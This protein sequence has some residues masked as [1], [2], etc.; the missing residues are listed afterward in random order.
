MA[1]K[2]TIG[3][4][5]VLAA[6]NSLA[7][8]DEKRRIINAGDSSFSNNGAVT[9]IEVNDKE[10]TLVILNNGKKLLSPLRDQ[11]IFS[12]AWEE[13]IVVLNIDGLVQFFD[14]SGKLLG[15]DKDSFRQST[16]LGGLIDRFTDNMLVITAQ[17]NGQGFDYFLSS[18]AQENWSFRKV[19]THKINNYG[20]VFPMKETIKIVSSV[21][22]IDIPRK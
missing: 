12:I 20:S 8:G 5:V 1:R 6:F 15:E 7:L 10:K 9:L 3:L 22:C 13:N 18:V 17:H 14:Q 11:A 2:L 21:G 19:W 16:I 4:L